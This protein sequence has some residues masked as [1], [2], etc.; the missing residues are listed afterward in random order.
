MGAMMHR[1]RPNLPA[2]FS[3]LFSFLGGILLLASLQLRDGFGASGSAPVLLV[4]CLTCILT[5]TFLII[6]FARYR[7]THL[8]K[9]TGAAH[10]DK[11]KHPHHHHHHHHSHR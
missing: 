6:A 4:V 2:L 3:A 10:S 9:G 11:Y 5:G 8:W 1:Q 7:F